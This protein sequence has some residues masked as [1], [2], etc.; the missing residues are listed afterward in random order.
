M[1]VSWSTISIY[2]RYISMSCNDC[3]QDGTKF[4]KL[5]LE[6]GL[7][8]DVGLYIVNSVLKYIY[9]NAI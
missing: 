9:I 8:N 2:E 1:S 4:S 3:N 7:I 5:F 6:S